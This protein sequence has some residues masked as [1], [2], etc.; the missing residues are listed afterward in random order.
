[1]ASQD[2][3]LEF[4]VREFA[5]SFGFSNIYSNPSSAAATPEAI[6]SPVAIPEAIITSE[7][8][9]FYREYERLITFG[10]WPKNFISP[11][12]LAKAGFYYLRKGDGVRCPFCDLILKGWVEGD[13]P[14]AE[15][16]L[17]SPTCPFIQNQD[18]GNIPLESSPELYQGYRNNKAPSYP[19]YATLEARLESY[20]TWPH[21][22]IPKPDALSDAGFFYTGK[23]D[24]TVCYHCGGRLRDWLDR[25]LPWVEHLMWFPKCSYVIAAKERWLSPKIIC[26]AKHT[27]NTESSKTTDDAD[28]GKRFILDGVCKICLSKEIGVMFLPCGHIAACVECA[29]NLITCAICRTPVSGTYRAFLS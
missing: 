7:N 10:Q 23:Q 6:R 2:E 29:V 11:R 16:K 13:E 9:R 3:T 27:G 1:M 8:A 19:T 21:F 17:W 26:D 20:K 15:H 28:G 24:E 18:V 4:I 25:Q 5:V 12:V 14:L 22:A